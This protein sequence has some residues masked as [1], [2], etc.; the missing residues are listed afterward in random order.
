MEEWPLAGQSATGLAQVLMALP[1]R[2]RPREQAG[3]AREENPGE[4][5]PPRG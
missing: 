2:S 3:P 4:K 5:E 1:P